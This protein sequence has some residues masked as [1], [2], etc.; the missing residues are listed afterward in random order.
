[1]Q[2]IMLFPDPSKALFPPKVRAAPPLHTIQLFTQSIKALNTSP[3]QI[4]MT[5]PAQHIVEDSVSPQP[6]DNKSELRTKFR[7]SPG[8]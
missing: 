2:P 6:G 4:T 1:M 3:A 5:T 7:A 8:Y